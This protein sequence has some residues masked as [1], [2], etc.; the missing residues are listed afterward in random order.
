MK[1]K[2]IQKLIAISV[3]SLAGLAYSACGQQTKSPTQNGLGQVALANQVY[4]HQVMGSD[5]QK[6]GNLNNLV[7]DLESGRILYG[8][9]GTGQSRVAAPPEIFTQTTPSGN[10]LRVNATKQKV[11]G[12]P[13]FGPVD[14]QGQWG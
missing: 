12:A 8:V 7:V 11:D 3:A 4:G 1:T 5:N 14:K 6:I 2:Y 13:K 9:I 10:E